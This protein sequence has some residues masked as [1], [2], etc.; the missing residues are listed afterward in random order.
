MLRL[1]APV[2]LALAARRQ[3]SAITAPNTSLAAGTPVSYFGGNSARRGDANIAMLAKMRMVMLEKWEGP[4]WAGCL[5]SNNSQPPAAACTAGC[6]VETHI[7]DTLRRVKARNPAVSGVMY[8]NTLLDF[9]FYSLHG[10]YV[11]AGA[12][13]MDSVTQKPIQ[14]RNDNG[15][16]GIFV[17]GFDTAAGQQ[18]YLD[19]VKNF[20]STGL[21]DG[22][23]GDKWSARAT[24]GDAADC[25]GA[26]CICNH[27]CGSMSAAQGQRWNAGKARVLGQALSIV[28]AGGPY[29][30]NGKNYS[31]SGSPD[32]PGSIIGTAGG[33]PRI[34]PRSGGRPLVA[35]PRD[36]VAAVK[37]ALKLHRFIRVGGG[38]QFWTTDPNDPASL[39]G[40]CLGDCHARFLLLW[41]PGVMMGSTGYDP[42]YDRPL[43]N[44]LGPAVYTPPA[45]AKATKHA[46][47]ATLTRQFTSGTKVVFTYSDVATGAGAGVIC[48]GGT[49]P[50]A[51]RYM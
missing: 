32:G 35:D 25:P 2:L 38:D 12:V 7:L 45:G 36:E 46:Q 13:A 44:P 24:P 5:A 9:P 43:G 15:M 47:P 4:C 39:G 41:E 37:A 42:I 40:S 50:P 33:G 16:E 29:Y 48:W 51:L 18:L 17:F 21:V 20:T 23:F 26:M 30:Q 14:I 3:V 27:E 8:L 19:A 6:G 28:G 34:A 10:Q 1:L 11:R 49:C 22:F 31:S